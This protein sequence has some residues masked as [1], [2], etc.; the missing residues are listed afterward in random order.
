[1]G[2]IR[3]RLS[4]SEMEVDDEGYYVDYIEYAKLGAER[5]R[6]REAL[7]WY[8]KIVSECNRHGAEGDIARGALAQDVGSKARAALKEDGDE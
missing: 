3:Y 1:M 6:L 8:E 2:V 4:E 7:Q 5:D